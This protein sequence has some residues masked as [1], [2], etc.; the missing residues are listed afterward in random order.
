MLVSI[1]VCLVRPPDASADRSATAHV[2][3][4]GPSPS[5]AEFEV[6]N[7]A[8]HT[9]RASVESYVGIGYGALQLLL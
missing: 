3:P 8:P 7:E 9:H 5:S 2:A 1:A 4:P 6:V